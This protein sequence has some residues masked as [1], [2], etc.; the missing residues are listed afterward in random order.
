MFVP[1]RKSTA[2]SA[3]SIEHVSGAGQATQSKC[4]RMKCMKMNTGSRATYVLC[5]ACIMSPR[6]HSPPNWSASRFN[7]H[8]YKSSLPDQAFSNS[9]R[10]FSLTSRS[11]PALLTRPGLAGPLKT[12]PFSILAAC[13]DAGLRNRGGPPRT[14]DRGQPILGEFARRPRG[15]EVGEEGAFHSGGSERRV[16]DSDKAS[17]PGEGGGAA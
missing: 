5:L 16:V 13:P 7:R 3:Q 1:M 8:A 10:I 9:L 14:G 2:V 6:S 17:L 15:E 12:N 4:K 11:P